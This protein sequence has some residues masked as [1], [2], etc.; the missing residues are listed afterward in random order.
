VISSLIGF[1]VCLAALVALIAA[2][3]WSM[4]RAFDDMAHG[5]WEPIP[6]DERHERLRRAISELEQEGYAVES[7]AVVHVQSARP[8]VVLV[9]PDGSMASVRVERGTVLLDVQTCLLPDVRWLSTVGA[10]AIVPTSACMLELAARGP[11]VAAIVGRHRASR[12]WLAD[13]GVALHAVPS[14]QAGR[15]Q[16][17]VMRADARN[18]PDVG[19]LGPLGVLLRVGSLRRPLWERPGIEAEID[20]LRERH[21]T[22]GLNP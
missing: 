21:S 8:A 13:R 22:G 11:D 4:R 14:G 16:E 1:V 3:R 5:R 7:F 19:F 10:A 15:E 18:P 20:A 9:H 17:A 6:P 12:E 2:F